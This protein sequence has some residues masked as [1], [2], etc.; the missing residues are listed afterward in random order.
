MCSKVYLF[1]FTRNLEKVLSLIPLNLILA[2]ERQ[3]EKQYFLKTEKKKNLY[4][5]F[6]SEIFESLSLRNKNESFFYQNLL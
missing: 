2:V 5:E 1:L 6:T 4:N 3:D